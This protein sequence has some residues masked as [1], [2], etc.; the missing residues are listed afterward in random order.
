MD[1]SNIDPLA[2]AALT[3]AVAGVVELLKRLFDK[4][5][6]TAAV[7]AVSAVAGA[8][9]APQAGDIT[10]FTGALVGL[11]ASGLITTVSHFGSK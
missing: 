7:I 8:V 3:F 9:L 4:D 6:R 1:F 11:S 5:W 10:M 2:L